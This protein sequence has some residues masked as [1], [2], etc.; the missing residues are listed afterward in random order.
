ME[1]LSQ[2]GVKIRHP[3]AVEI[4]KSH[5]IR[6]EGDVVFFTEEQIMHWVGMAPASFTIHAKNP[7]Y[8]IIMGGSHVN[9][10]PC[11]GSP[12]ISDYDGNCRQA[13]MADYVKLLK[14]F[15]VNDNFSINGGIPVQPSDI[16]ADTSCLPM[17]YANCFYSDK[18]LLVGP[19]S[20]EVFRTMLN[21]AEIWFGGKDHLRQKPSIM[22]LVS[23]NSPLQ[24]DGN[25]MSALIELAK[26]GQVIII[27][28]G[29]M[30]GTTAAITMAG[31]IATGSSSGSALAD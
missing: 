4:M 25:M 1:I 20:P 14:L 22:G 21:A 8:D 6:A 24:I 12:F 19:G 10:A 26:R 2:I 13:L 7:K 30:M 29:G 23:T 3:E 11:Y 17:F 16:D 18:V 15:H 31:A 28:G 5:G 9:L 27:S